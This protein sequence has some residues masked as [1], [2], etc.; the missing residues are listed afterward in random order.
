MG[1]QAHTLRDYNKPPVIE[2]VLSIQ[3]A[4]IQ[5]LSIPHLG[6]Y[7]AKI[8]QN[9]PHAEIRP[10]LG[11]TKEE[12]TSR[13]R[14][15]A[16]LG[17]EMVTEPSLRCWFTH[18]D[19]NQL[20]QVQKDRFIYN[21]KKSKETETYPRYE[22]IKERCLLEW[23]YFIAFLHEEG[24]SRPEANQCEVTY[25]NHIEYEQG[26]RTFGELNK[27]IAPWSGECSGKFLPAPESVGINASYVL[28]NNEGR[29]YISME[30]VIRANDAKEVLQLTLTARGGPSSST[31]EDIFR[32]LDL[33]REW[34][35]EG[36]TD[37]TTTA[38]HNRWGRTK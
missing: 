1:S 6:L 11:Q 21:W 24:L 10:P 30:P 38:F 2:T 18:S 17:L 14:K 13:T 12:F 25:V 27:V 28:R 16:D 7:W 35:V 29:L 9:Y 22:K 32:W 36:F 15:R 5:G 4:P 20:I 26:W 8:R 23:E 19:M 3:F 31:T 33:G 37:F 34:V